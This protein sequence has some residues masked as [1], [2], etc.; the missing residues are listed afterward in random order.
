MLIEKSAGAVVFYRERGGKIKYLLLEH[1]TG[2]WAFPKGLMEKNETSEETAIREIQEETGIKNFFLIPGFK[3]I[4]KY[5]FK[6]KYDYQLKRGWKK[7]ERV[8]KIV[9]FFLAEAKTKKVKISFEHKSFL[10]LDYKSA[11]ER[12]SFSAAR[13]I[14]KKANDFLKSKLKIMIQKEK[15]F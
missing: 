2:H 12:I 3:E 10:W 5:F 6:V 9:T 14:L 7:G 13:K 1:Q 11:W 15:F 4:E 8:L